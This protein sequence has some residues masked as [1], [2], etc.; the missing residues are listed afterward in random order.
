MTE[1]M[2]WGRDAWHGLSCAVG[3]APVF[4]LMPYG[5]SLADPLISKSASLPAYRRNGLHRVSVSCCSLPYPTTTS[6]LCQP[7]IILSGALLEWEV[8]PQ[9]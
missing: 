9:L 2:H 7:Q 5:G 4:S 8:Q 3:P 6:A 1:G